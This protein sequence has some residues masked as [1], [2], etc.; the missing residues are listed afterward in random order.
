MTKQ[1]V[2]IR[3]SKQKN[4]DNKQL[5][6]SKRNL[7]EALTHFKR[8]YTIEPK[9]SRVLVATANAAFDLQKYDEALEYYVKA[10]QADRQTGFEFR[11]ATNTFRLQKNLNW[12]NKYEVGW[13][14]C[15]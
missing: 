8:A 9:S 2:S 12:Q 3:F 5:L 6:Y 1:N 7:E 14:K 13:G 11:R 10:C 4:E 15:P